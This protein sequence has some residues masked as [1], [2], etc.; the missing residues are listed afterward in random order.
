MV[1][2]GGWRVEDTELELFEGRICGHGFRV[3]GFKD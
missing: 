2:G 1:E 3:L